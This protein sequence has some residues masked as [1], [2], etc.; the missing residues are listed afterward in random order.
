MT[1]ILQPKTLDPFQQ[2]P[3]VE[4]EVAGWRELRREIPCKDKELADRW[5]G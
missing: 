4:V 2:E 3:L 5:V 1:R